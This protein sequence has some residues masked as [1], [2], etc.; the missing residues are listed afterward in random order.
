MAGG[1]G[2]FICKIVP[3]VHLYKTFKTELKHCS[4]CWLSR[5]RQ[6]RQHLR[7]QANIICSHFHSEQNKLIF[8]TLTS[9]TATVLSEGWGHRSNTRRSSGT[10]QRGCVSQDPKENLVIVLNIPSRAVEVPKKR[11][12]KRAP[13]AGASGAF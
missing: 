4:L 5:R 10:G 1:M 9:S 13:L 3:A 6:L 7:D 2:N 11:L 8:F 12:L